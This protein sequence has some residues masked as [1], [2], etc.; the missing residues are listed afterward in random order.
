MLMLTCIRT[1]RLTCARPPEKS[2]SNLLASFDETDVLCKSK[3]GKFDQF[4]LTGVTFFKIQCAHKPLGPETLGSPLEA[5]A[6]ESGSE[7][8]SFLTP[9]WRRGGAR[10]FI[11]V[12]R[13]GR[14]Q[15][16]PV[17]T[18]LTRTCSSGSA[19]DARPLCHAWI[20]VLSVCAT[21]LKITCGYNRTQRPGSTIARPTRR[22]ET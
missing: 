8:L 21:G 7:L 18:G 5:P 2:K 19:V 3:H 4:M 12:F 15:E 20:P 16:A 14:I 17:P 1:S 22:R 6:W 13:G 9:E 11:G 10:S